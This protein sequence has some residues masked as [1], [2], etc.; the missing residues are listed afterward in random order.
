MRVLILN[1]FF[2]PDISATSQLMTDLAEDLVKMGA[3]VTALCCRNQ[4]IKGEELVSDEVYKGIRIVRVAVTQFDRASFVKRGVS[5]LSFYVSSF[6]KL[7]RLNR[8]DVILVLTTPPLIASVACMIKAISRCRVIYL[9]QDLYPDV[10]V[11]LGVLKEKSSFTRLLERVSK[12][13]LS[14]SDAIIALGD[15]MRRRIEE[16][17]TSPKKIHVIPNWADGD[18]IRTI[19]RSENEFLREHRLTEKFVVFYSGNMGK[20]HDFDTILEAVRGLSSHSDIVFVFV[21]DGPKRN[22]ISDFIKENPDVN[23]LLLPYRQRDELSVS[24]GAADVSLVTLSKGMEGLVVP[25]KVYGVMAAG[26]P[27]IFIGQKGSEAAN[28]IENASCGYV[29]P[30]GQVSDL[31]NAILNLKADKC[32]AFQMGKNSRES[33]ETKFDRRLVTR[34]YFDLIKGV[35]EANGKN[36]QHSPSYAASRTTDL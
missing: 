10:A 16:K 20:V 11:Q 7:I 28:T 17:G 3:D 36:V 30:N 15:C 9:V 4:Y 32:L 18:Q 12:T 8:P 23:I 19:E 1:Q 29:I 33:F 6:F 25:S 24:L 22:L 13:T 34:R 5:Y 21:G 2:Y 31:K 14:R 26:R 27:I 35:M